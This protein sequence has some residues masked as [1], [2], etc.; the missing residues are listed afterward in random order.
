[1]RGYPAITRFWIDE[2]EGDKGTRSVL[3]ILEATDAEG[4]LTRFQG[5]LTHQAATHNGIALAAVGQALP[6]PMTPYSEEKRET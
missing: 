6:Q 5:L 4:K 2:V 1:M 3:L